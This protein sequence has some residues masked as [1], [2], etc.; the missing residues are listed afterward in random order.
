MSRKLCEIICWLG[1]DGGYSVFSSFLSMEYIRPLRLCRI[2]LTPQVSDCCLQIE[3][4]VPCHRDEICQVSDLQ[5]PH[6][7]VPYATQH[8]NTKEVRNFSWIAVC[9]SLC[10]CESCV[11]TSWIR[12]FSLVSVEKFIFYGC[13][14]WGCAFYESSMDPNV[15]KVGWKERVGSHVF[16]FGCL[17]RVRA[18]IEQ[19]Q[20]HHH[21][22]FAFHSHFHNTIFK[23][24]QFSFFSNHRIFDKFHP[25]L[26]SCTCIKTPNFRESVLISIKKWVVRL[27]KR[28]PQSN[29]NYGLAIF[30]Q[31]LSRNNNIHPEWIVLNGEKRA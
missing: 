22:T 27:N 1:Q 21:H 14:S 10:V 29:L 17:T 30:S 16:A 5:Y 13:I 20:R 2:V 4:R 23:W 3:Q 28:D 15:V 25:P 18:S 7:R 8:S 11:Y 24:N 31:R 26:L 9:F 19:Q 12:R 6:S